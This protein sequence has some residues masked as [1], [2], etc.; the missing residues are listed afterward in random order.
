MGDGRELLRE[1]VR[2]GDRLA[3]DSLSYSE[4]EMRMPATTEWRMIKAE[5]EAHLGGEGSAS[6][7]APDPRPLDIHYEPRIDR[8]TIDGVIYSG[9]IFRAFGSAPGTFGPHAFRFMRADDGKTIM[10]ETLRDDVCMN[11]LLDEEIERADAQGETHIVKEK[12][13]QTYIEPGER[14]RRA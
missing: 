7:P 12:P 11:D 8:L 5:I 13:G 4:W 14:V 1:A 10:M 2:R 6:S 9:D 3:H